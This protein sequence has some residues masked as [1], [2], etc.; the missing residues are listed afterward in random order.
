[1]KAYG[2]SALAAF[3]ITI[4]SCATAPKTAEDKA[5][6]EVQA[7]ATL[8]SMRGREPS[9]DHFLNR[10]SGYVV[11]PEIG[12]AGFIAGAGYGRGILFEHGVPA[13]F[14]ELNQGS[15]GAQIGAQAFSE[16]IVLETPSQ[17]N[18]IKGGDFAV[19][20]DVS[21]VVL[22][23]GA[24]AQADFTNGIAVFVMPKGGLMAEV[25]V[26]GQKINF[27]PRNPPQG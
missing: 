7:T 1:M 8:R 5:T 25:S 2:W 16:L 12:K 23:A 24:A 17:V 22:T 20:G 10:A 27:Q 4:T 18:D 11:F 21:A 3:M 13:G 14:V 9:I 6:L 19:S 26:S 15:F